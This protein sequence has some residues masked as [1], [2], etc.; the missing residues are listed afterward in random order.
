M[1]VAL[2]AAARLPVQRLV[3]HRFTIE[4]AAEAYR[5]LDE[6]PKDCLQVLLTYT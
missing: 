4:R 1:K 3:S 2:Q 6:S 5:L